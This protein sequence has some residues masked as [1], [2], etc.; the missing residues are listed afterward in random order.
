MEVITLQYRFWASVS[1]VNSLRIDSLL[2][3]NKAVDLLKQYK[4]CKAVKHTP[5]S[6]TCGH[7]ASLAP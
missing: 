1:P 5:K 2:N 7:L 6:A 4:G 3:V